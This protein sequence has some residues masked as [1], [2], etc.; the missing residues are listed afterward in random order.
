ESSVAASR[1]GR[2]RRERAGPP[3][4]GA[5]DQ[6]R[7]RARR[8]RQG[9]DRQVDH[10]V[11]PVGGVRQA[12]EARAADRVRPQARLDVHAHEA[13]GPHR[14]RL[15]RAGGLP[16]RGAAGG[17]LRVRG[18]RGGDV[19]GG[20]RPAG[21]HGVRRLRGGADGEAAQRAP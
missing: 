18:V 13:D 15:A 9:R 17:G 19:R 7:A 12:G 1:D 20:G 4:P 6:R 21:R 3:R 11:E 2:R 10:V 8:V 16:R 14:D 5:E